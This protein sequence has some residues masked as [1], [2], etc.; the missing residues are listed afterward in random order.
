MK[1]GAHL[2]GFLAQFKALVKYFPK[3]LLVL[4]RTESCVHKVDSDNTTVESS[5]ELIVSVLI[6]PRSEETT[7]SHAREHVALIVLLHYLR[8]DEVRIHSLGCT[9]YCEVGKPSVFGILVYIVLV[10]NVEEFR[11]SRRYP[12]AVLVKHALVTEL[13]HLFDK[14]C[15]LLDI[16]RLLVKVHEYAHERRLTVG[17]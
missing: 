3:I 8:R 6:L 17:G 2:K 16:F 5:V 7:A 14:H 12:Y 11:E 10:K 1:L 13:N 15:R 4:P 9:L